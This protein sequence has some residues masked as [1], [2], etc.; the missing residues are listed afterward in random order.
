[1][2]THSPFG[3]PPI[4]PITSPS[5]FTPMASQSPFTPHAS[6][7]PFTPMAS[8]SPG[9]PVST[10][11]Q[12]TAPMEIGG[13]R[14]ARNCPIGPDRQRDWSFGL[15]DCLSRCGT[16]CWSV[17]CPCVVY[18]NNR[19]RLHSLQHQGT[20]VPRGGESLGAYC[21]IYFVLGCCGLNW[22][23]QMQ[24]RADVRLRYNIRG[25]TIGDCCTSCCCAPCALTQERR[26]IECEENS[27]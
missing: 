10:Q 22:V 17:W 11:P 9:Q 16:C 15:C 3:S 19:Q 20:P 14:N 7:S 25:S 26:E 18:S 27:F 12:R 2:A 1:M 24:T 13:N 6:Q 23:L 4:I 21:C 5:P 8:Q